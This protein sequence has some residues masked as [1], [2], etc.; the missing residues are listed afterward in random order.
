MKNSRAEE[1]YNLLNPLASDND[2]QYE[3]WRNILKEIPEAERKYVLVYLDN[4]VTEFHFLDDEGEY[5]DE[6]KYIE[7]EPGI[8][9]QNTEPLLRALGFNAEYV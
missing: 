1:L 3:F 9:W 7:L 6:R 4:D 8:Y 5:V 2:K